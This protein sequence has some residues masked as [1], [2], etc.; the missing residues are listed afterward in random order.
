M[1][2]N[3]FRGNVTGISALKKTEPRVARALTALPVL[4]CTVVGGQPFVILGG[5]LN[6]YIVVHIH[7]VYT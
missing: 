2:I 6:M 5:L 3:Y 1:K 7:K 4:A